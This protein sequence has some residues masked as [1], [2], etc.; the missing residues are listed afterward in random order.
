MGPGEGDP[1]PTVLM[2]LGWNRPFL[3]EF[4]ICRLM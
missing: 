1:R 2:S 4:F 3:N